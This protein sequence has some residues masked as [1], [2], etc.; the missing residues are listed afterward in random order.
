MVLETCS[1][2]RWK[3]LDVFC[4]LDFF[5]FALS[6]LIVVVGA[7]AFFGWGDRTGFVNASSL[8]LILSGFG[9]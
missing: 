7:S 9:L 6:A 3:C 2:I 1:F 5:G 8:G 4:R